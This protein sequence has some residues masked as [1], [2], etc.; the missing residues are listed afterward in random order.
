MQRRGQDLLADPYQ[1]PNLQLDSLYSVDPFYLDL[2]LNREEYEFFLNH[3]QKDWVSLSSE[4]LG[5]KHVVGRQK[6][7]EKK[8]KLPTQAAPSS[9]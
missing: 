8:K 6:M 2:D 4:K 9:I 3:D 1:N 7:K 5:N